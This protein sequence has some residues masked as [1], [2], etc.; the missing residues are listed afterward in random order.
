MGTD[1]GDEAGV[2]RE[3]GFVQEVDGEGVELHA[4][5]EEGVE[6]EGAGGGGEGGD[7]SDGWE[8]SGHC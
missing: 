6:D 1:C 2:G 8:G 4:G 7:G 3:R 5:F